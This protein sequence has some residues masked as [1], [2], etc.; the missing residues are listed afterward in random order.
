VRRLFL[1]ALVAAACAV[2]AAPA[3]ATNECRGLQVCVPVAGPWVLASPAQVE[4]QL[5]CP[6]RFVVGGLDA[7]LSIRG[8]D[9]G[10]VGNL[11]SP[12]NPGITTSKEA[13]FLGRLVRGSDPAASFRPHIG[14]IPA[15]GG[16]QRTPTAY[17][18]F[19]PGKPSVRHVTQFVVQPGRT[20]H[21]VKTCA[22]NE[23]LV[24][25]THAIG[26]FGDKPPSASLARSVEVAQSVHAGRVRL[27]IRAARALAGGHAVVQ[28]DLVCAPR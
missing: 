4:F 22:R 20:R 11:G 10:F 12:V 15:S 24:A 5:A 28:L 7:E 16:G 26:F 9:I 27:T 6:T 3:Y 21:Y 18:P 2:V 19:K 14:C 1:L 8:I 25:A 23:S 13:V 17:H